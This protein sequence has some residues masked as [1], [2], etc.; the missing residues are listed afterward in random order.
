MVVALPLRAADD[1]NFNPAITQADFSKFSR[2]VAQGIFPSPIQP[3]GAA[4]L[5]RFDISVAAT[6]VQIDPQATYWT[7]AV[8]KD[9]T[10]GD[11]YVAVPRLVVSKG[12]GAAAVSG[13]YAKL[14]NSGGSIL[15]GTLDVPII[16]GGVLKPT[17]ALRGSY[18]TLQGIDVYKMN[19]YGAEL[20]LGKGFGPI[21]PYGAVG[22][23][24][25]DATG[26]IPATARTPVVTLK[27][28]STITRYTLGAAIN[29]LVLR[30]NV[31]ANQAEER[32]YGA[33]VG[34]GF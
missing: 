34:F 31:E 20:F 26:T 33:K 5:L 6:A 29:L 10:L 18:S 4:G 8:S 3:G 32:S 22:K 23:Q 25:G 14:G 24:R 30:I 16:N 1:I 28:K 17:L 21:T 15:G 9:I 12:L 7:R 2:I 19:T 13:S 11:N 27:D